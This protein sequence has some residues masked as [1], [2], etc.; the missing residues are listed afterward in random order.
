MTAKNVRKKDSAP[1]NIVATAAGKSALGAGKPRATAAGKAVLST[2]NE[3]KAAAF[4]AKHAKVVSAAGKVYSVTFSSASKR[5]ASTTI[6]KSAGK[7]LEA[8]TT[9]APQEIVKLDL[10]RRK[11]VGKHPEVKHL[12]APKS[13]LK[14]DEK[15]RKLLLASM[16]LN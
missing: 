15:T 7:V 12:P 4:P 2:R 16:V 9:T 13:K 5:G 3:S 8:R 11:L 6:T 10:S 14:L 1:R